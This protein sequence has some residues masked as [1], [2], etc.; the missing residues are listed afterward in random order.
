MLQLLGKIV[1]SDVI[2]EC[3]LHTK[4]LRS[5]VMVVI[6]ELV[7]LLVIVVFVAVVSELLLA[8]E[9]V[10]SLSILKTIT[11]FEDNIINFWTHNWPNN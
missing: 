2:T 3:V 11:F 1:S 10:N 8:M 5:V 6:M 9:P 7:V 4:P